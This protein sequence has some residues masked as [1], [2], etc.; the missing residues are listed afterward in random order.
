MITDDD[1][2]DMFHDRIVKHD[3]VPEKNWK[4]YHHLRFVHYDIGQGIG[5]HTPV[6]LFVASVFV[7]W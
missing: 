6:I 1:M 3:L 5:C 7:M 4:L 2:L